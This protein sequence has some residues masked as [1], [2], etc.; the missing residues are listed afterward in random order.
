VSALWAA[1]QRGEEHAERLWPVLIAMQ[2]LRAT[3]TSPS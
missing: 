2:W 1:H 3:R